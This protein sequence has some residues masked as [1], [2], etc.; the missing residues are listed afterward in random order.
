MDK[1]ETASEQR[2]ETGK[3]DNKSR[4]TDRQKGKWNTGN[5]RSVIQNRAVQ[6][7]K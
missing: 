7:R 3:G 5:R 2:P 1:S 6:G 4:Q